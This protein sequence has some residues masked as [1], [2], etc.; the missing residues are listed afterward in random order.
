MKK[1]ISVRAMAV[2]A[3]MSALAFVLMLLEF[4]V[5]FV[6]SFLKFD[7]S[8][9]PAFL[10]SFAISPA[11]GVAVE[12]LKNLLH[13]PFTATSGVG[14]LANFIIGAAYVLP[15]GIIYKHRK[16]RGG[17]LLGSAAGTLTA[18]LVSLPVN[19]FITYPFYSNFM[20]MDA[21]IGAYAA[22]FPWVD[23]L[24][25]ALATVNLPFTFIKGGVNVVITFLIYKPLSP[26]LKGTQKPSKKTK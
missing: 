4:S 7:F 9:L 13:L 21:I 23:G 20:P 16:T 17:A 3:I 11:A 12:L 15:A 14:E 19:Y 2:T 5:P 10:V 24:L 25:K 18:A 6:P 26:I 22:I 8:D 1:K